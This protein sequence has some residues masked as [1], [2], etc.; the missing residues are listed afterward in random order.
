MN[1]L[2]RFAK[3]CLVLSLLLGF[4]SC[5]TKNPEPVN[6]QEE[7]NRLDITF[8]PRGGGQSVTFSFSDPDGPGGNPPQVSTAPLRANTT[9]DARIEL[10][11]MAADGRTILNNVTREI[12]DDAAAHQFFFIVNPQGLINQSYA[13]TDRNNRPLGLRNTIVTGNAGSGN[14]RIVLRHNLDKAF[15]GLNISNF[16]QAGGATDIDVNFDFS[17]Q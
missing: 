8:S 7:M 1:T 13:D 14:L 17:V 10:F 5:Q 9:Y 12:Q 2:W 3:Y 16:Q 4:E 15:P 11:F 6:Q